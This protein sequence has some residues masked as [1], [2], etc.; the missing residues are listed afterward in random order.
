MQCLTP[1]ASGWRGNGN[2]EVASR[3]TETA[4]LFVSTY[5]S[6]FPSSIIAAIIVGTY[7]DDDDCDDYDDGDDN[8]DDG[9]I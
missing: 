2:A 8:D 5:R 7:H 4:S 6:L 1:L 3:A 9:D